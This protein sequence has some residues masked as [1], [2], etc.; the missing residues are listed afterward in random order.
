MTGDERKNLAVT[1]WITAVAVAYAFV[2]VKLWHDAPSMFGGRVVIAFGVA[3]IL[4]MISLRQNAFRA[5][6]VLAALVAAT[7]IV[8]CGELVPALAA[9]A[10]L[11]VCYGIGD[12]TLRALSV[13]DLR[14][15]SRFAIAV[16]L[17]VAMFAAALF[18]LGVLQL[19]FEVSIA[20]VLLAGGILSIH[21]RRRRAARPVRAPKK[22][23]RPARPER[24]PERFFL[25]AMT[26]MALLLGLPAALAPATHY[27]ALNYHLPVVRD[28]L[29]AHT[30]IALPYWHS[31]L[32]HLAEA[33]FVM[34]M[35]LAG[36]P[37]VK[38]V[39]FGLGMVLLAASWALCDE[40][41]GRRAADW[42]AAILATTPIMAMIATDVWADTLV[43]LF[44]TAAV[45]SFPFVIRG[46][47]GSGAALLVGVLAGAA[48]GTKLNAAYA[49]T[50][51]AA[52]LG[53][54]AW[55]RRIPYMTA[56]RGL[57][58]MA[59]VAS[60][61]FVMTYVFTGNP[62][63]PFFNAIFRSPL[64]APIN[65]LMNA[66]HY[67]I[68]TGPIAWLRMPFAATFETHRFAEILPD[69]CIGFAL[70]AL[71][72]LLA[73]PKKTLDWRHGLAT[74]VAITYG[75]ALAA[76]FPYAR[77]FTVVLPLL[78]VLAAG[79]VVS[80][81]AGVA[82]RIALFSIGGAILVQLSILAFEFRMLDQWRWLFPFGA[83]SAEDY[84]RRALPGIDCVRELDRNISSGDRV[85][86][87]QAAD[88]RYFVA[89]PMDSASES[90]AFQL[91]T[92]GLSGE[93]LRDSLWNRKDRF[94]MIRLFPSRPG[95]P[96]FGGT[97]FFDRFAEPVCSSGPVRVFR[98]L[99]PGLEREKDP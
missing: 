93:A 5:A 98:V 74:V 10:V 51:L 69:G 12:A 44:I 77:Y 58:A 48:V 50:P 25:G 78:A 60:P 29:A 3:A 38:L 76:T 21:Y 39:I 57:L 86:E 82:R 62:V 1:G 83:E 37:A 55:R 65:H 11:A 72:V 91:A 99:A 85:A 68:G 13:P 27:D 33:F 56:A 70:L 22:S 71:P 81:S 97:A 64:A 54:L 96:A 88:F 90:R 23:R 8:E 40:L 16:P 28:W 19:L 61:W 52:A 67:G 4:A 89:A 95:A 45:I 18:L 94:V 46:A 73:I 75:I 87:D 63:F 17:G 15:A 14:F 31:N 26:G 43:A 84:R 47:E 49:A 34:P 42:S 2:A 35:A 20:V 92:A 79:A 32:A 24:P 41:F 80:M 36:E 9:A 53:L 30:I 66:E 59:L 6:A 7:M